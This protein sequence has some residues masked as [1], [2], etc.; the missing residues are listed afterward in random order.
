MALKPLDVT[1][2]WTTWNEGGGRLDGAPNPPGVLG[3]RF[4]QKR[5]REL[6]EVPRKPNA[7][8]ELEGQIDSFVQ[9]SPGVTDALVSR[10]P[11]P[12]ARSASLL[13]TSASRSFGQL[14]AL[15]EERQSSPAIT[16]LEGDR[17]EQGQRLRSALVVCKSPVKLETPFAE[18]TRLL[19]VAADER[20]Y[21]QAVQQ[22]RDAVFVPELL[23]LGEALLPEALGEVEL[24]GEVCGAAE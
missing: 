21:R 24:A 13:A 22:H 1:R 20:G 18:R 15:L 12:R 23:V 5:K 6:A 3:P 9:K 10:S 16:R 17:A 8:T 2:P 14:G 4:V 11:P 7:I 19:D